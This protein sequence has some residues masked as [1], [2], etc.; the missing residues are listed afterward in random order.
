MGAGFA[1]MGRQYHIEVSGDDYYIDWHIDVQYLPTP[2]FGD[3][4]N[5]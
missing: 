4:V 2:L 3:R 1:F 5:Q